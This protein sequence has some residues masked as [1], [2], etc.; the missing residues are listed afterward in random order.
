MEWNQVYLM[1][2][3]DFLPTFK[4][5]RGAQAYVHW[6]LVFERSDNFDYFAVWDLGRGFD[7]FEKHRASSLWLVLQ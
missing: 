4:F 7:S 1:V 5:V 2:E 6:F 3:L